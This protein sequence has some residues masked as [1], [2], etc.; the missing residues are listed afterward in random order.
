[1]KTAQ[2][3]CILS[4]FILST[5]CDLAAANKTGKETPRLSA[6]SRLQADKLKQKAA[7]AK[8]F[9][10]QRNYN[11]DFCVLADM[12]I[13]SGYERMVVWNFKTDTVERSLLVGHGCGENRWSY[14]DSKEDPVFSNKD[15]SHC[16]SLG[17]YK[18]GARGVSQ[19]GIKVKYLLHG[20]DATNSNALKRTIVLHS[21]ELMPDEEVYPNGSPEGWGCPTVS[22]S[23]MRYLDKK[24]SA[25]KK[26]ALLWMFK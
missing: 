11:T 16:S 25:I 4:L 7:E 19:W 2:L 12:S 3:I 5:G 15:G 18:I 1:M 8:T 21:W 26:P 23:S 22:D 13:H 20:L 6:A 14:D 17:R 24:L 10:M 9:C